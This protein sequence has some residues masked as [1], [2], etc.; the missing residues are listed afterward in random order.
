MIY[1]VFMLSL[2]T[3]LLLI[4]N[5]LDIFARHCRLSL[6]DDVKSALDVRLDGLEYFK[7][8]VTFLY[9]LQEVL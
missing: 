7:M 4:S 9:F 1:I 6:M 3:V 8:L 5:L 2:L